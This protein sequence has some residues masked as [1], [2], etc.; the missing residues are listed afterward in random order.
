MRFIPAFR[1]YPRRHIDRPTGPPNP[2]E[3]YLL[4]I[5]IAQG[6]AVIFGYARPPSIQAALPGWLRGVWGVLLLIGG[7]AAVIGLYWPWDALDA[8]LIK[9]VGL[10]AAAGGTLAYGVALLSLG[11]AGFVAAVFNLGFALACLVRASQITRAL[12]KFRS[13]MQSIR[14]A[15]IA[16]VMHG[17]SP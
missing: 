14:E 17:G 8:I 15:R 2:F 6:C 9:R 1:E 11:S 4:V 7:L 13:D 3:S 5:C 12:N 10:L 16:P